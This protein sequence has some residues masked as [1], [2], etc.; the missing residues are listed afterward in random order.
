VQC[1]FSDVVNKFAVMVAVHF[2]LRYA[3]N[4]KCVLVILLKMTFEFPMLQLTGE[5]DNFISF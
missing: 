4:Q 3:N 1:H 5:A 2:S